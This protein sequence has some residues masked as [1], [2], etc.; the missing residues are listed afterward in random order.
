MTMETILGMAGML[1]LQTSSN[2]RPAI[3]DWLK[4]EGRGAEF[5]VQVNQAVRDGKLT[6]VPPVKCTL[7]GYRGEAYFSVAGYGH[8]SSDAFIDAL[9]LLSKSGVLG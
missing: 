1:R 4:E 7:R 5:E 9:S 8:T 2:V 3:D 6:T